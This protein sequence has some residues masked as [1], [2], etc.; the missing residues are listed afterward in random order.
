MLTLISIDKMDGFIEHLC[1]M[2]TIFDEFIP[3]GI[4]AT[5]VDVPELKAISDAI[6]SLVDKNVNWEDVSARL[7]DETK[8]LKK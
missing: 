2:G 4:L 3:I 7:F 6:E 5:S 8:N 1:T